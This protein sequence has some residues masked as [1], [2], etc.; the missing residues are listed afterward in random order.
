MRNFKKVWIIIIFLVLCF[1]ISSLFNFILVPYNYIRVDVH[2]LQTNKYDD[3][4]IGTSHGKAGINPKVVDKVTG[5]KSTNLCLGGEYLEDSYFLVKEAARHHKPKRVIYEVDPG[6]WVTKPS[7][8]TDYN[9]IYREFPMSTVKLEYYISKNLKADF[10]NTIFPWYT[11]RN[12][13]TAIPSIIKTKLSNEYRNYGIKNFKAP[14]Q[15][16]EPEGFIH[17]NPMEG[18][19]KSKE[20]LILWDKDR[21]Y[22]GNLKYFDK[23]AK[24]CKK[25]EIELIAITTPIPSETLNEYKECYEDAN[26]YFTKLMKKYD[27]QYYNFNYIEDSKIDR[28]LDAYNDYD[29]HMY[30]KTANEFSLVLGNYLNERLHASQ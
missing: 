30:G 6:Y 10:R 9:L 1:G 26:T 18:V 19:P 2:N 23:L 28:R 3:L 25:E 14:N 7:Q 12:Q 8:N 16:Y 20:N 5:R 13:Y 11:C 29:G 24:Y 27:I 17:I 15:S 4:Y 21:I 22:K